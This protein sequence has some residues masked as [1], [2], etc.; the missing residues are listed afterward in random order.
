MDEVRSSNQVPMDD[1]SMSSSQMEHSE[2][3][4]VHKSV[5]EKKNLTWIDEMDNFLVDRLMEQMHKGQKIGGVFTKTAYVIVAREIGE[6]FELSCNSEHIKNRMKTLKKNFYAAQEVL[7]SGSGFGFNESTQ[8]IEATT[9]VWTT[10][11]KVS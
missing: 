2:G 6:N 8:M 1:G 7:Q 3:F 9:E 11:T 5:S 10:Y 4:E